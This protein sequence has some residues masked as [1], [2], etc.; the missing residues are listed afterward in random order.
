MTAILKNVF[1]NRLPEL[2]KEYNN[3]IYRA[4]KMKLVD[5]K[6]NTFY[7]FYVE[8]NTKALNMMW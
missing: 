7:Q 8:F 1:I 5:I 2:V 6:Y 3:T 4:M